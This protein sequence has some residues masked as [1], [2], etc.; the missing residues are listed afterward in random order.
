MGFGVL[1]AFV[2]PVFV[3]GLLLLLGA[4]VS[5]TSVASVVSRASVVSGTVVASVVGSVVGSVVAS[6]VAYGII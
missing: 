3:A 2:L 1:F 6:V 4:V 5:G